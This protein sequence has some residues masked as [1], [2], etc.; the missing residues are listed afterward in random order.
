MKRTKRKYLAALIILTML[1][2]L[3]PLGGLT[4]E[5][6]DIKGHWAEA[7]IQ[8]WLDQGMAGGYPDGAFW[9]DN[10]VTR[11]EFIVLVNRAFD[12]PAFA[13]GVNFA[14]VPDTAWY[15]EDIA[16]AVKAEI[17]SGY[18]DGTFRP[19]AFIT[20][21]EA[22]AVLER[23]LKDKASDVTAFTDDD[24]ITSWA[25]SAVQAISSAGIMNGYP[26]G[27]FRPQNPITR[28]E[29]VVV[30]DRI[31][32][33]MEAVTA[34]ND[35]DYYYDDYSYTPTVSLAAIDD[36]TLKTGQSRD[37]SIDSNATSITA[38]S[39]N[40]DVVSVSVNDKTLTIGGLKKGSAK[41]SVTGMRGGYNSRT[42]TFT[43]EVTD[44]EVVG[45]F[46]VTFEGNGGTPA[47][48]TKV[49]ADGNTVGTLPTVTRD[50]FTFV[51]WNTA[52]NGSGTAFTA[53]T[54]V[55][56]D[57]TVYADWKTIP[58][59]L[60]LWLDA[61]D[62]DESTGNWP[63]KSIE[64]NEVS[65]TEADSR[66]VKAE[67]GFNERP[68]V[69]FDGID[70]YLNLNWTAG[71]FETDEATIFMVL[72]S[73]N[74]DDSQTVMG[75]YG[76]EGAV[77]FHV[78]TN[79]NKLTATV[80]NRGDR[81]DFSDS[82]E[83]YI[84]TYK[85]TPT[86]HTAYVDGSQTATGDLDESINWGTTTIGKNGGPVCDNIEEW[87]WEGNIAEIRIYDHALSDA[88]REEVEEELYD[89]WFGPLDPEPVLAVDFTAVPSLLEETS[90][91]GTGATVGN[92]SVTNGI[93]SITYS[94]TA[95]TG[96]T[97]NG[98][99]TIQGNEVKVGSTALTKGTYS[100][101]V[102]AIDSESNLAVKEFSI[103]VLDE[104]AL[105]VNNPYAGVNWDTVN[106]YKANFHTHTK[107]SSSSGY[108]SDGDSA[109]D[110]VIKAYSDAGYSILALTDHDYSTYSTATTWPWTEFISETPSQI[111][112][113]SGETS[114]D[115]ET[116]ALYPDLGPDGMLA[117]RGNELSNIDHTGSLFSEYGGA[118]SGQEEQALQQIQNRKGLA[119]M[120]H[121]GRYD[122]TLSW[123]ENLYSEY[124]E[125]PLIGMEVYNQGDRYSND[126]A[127]WD[128]LNAALM[129]EKVVFGYSDDDM[130]YLNTHT[131][132]N[133]QFM[134]M[135]ELTEEALRGA[136]HTGASY[137][138]YEPNR[139]G[140]EDP[141]VPRI[142]KIEVT[143]SGTV[144]TITATNAETITWRTNKGIAAT[145]SSVDL[146]TL[147]LAE[148]KFIRAELENNSGTTYTQPFTLGG[149]VPNPETE[150]TVTFSSSEKGSLSAAVDGSAITSGTKVKA[151]KTVVFTAA[152][153]ADY[154]VAEWS[155]NET[156][157]SGETGL[158]YIHANLSGDINVTVIFSEIGS[159]PEPILWLDAADYDAN[160]GQWPDKTGINSVTQTTT[161]SRPARVTDGFNG[162]PIVR[163]DGTEQY[164]S[165]DWGTSLGDS[166]QTDE[167]TIFLVMKDGGVNA[168]QVIMG[169]YNAKDQVAVSKSSQSP[170][171][172]V[173]RIYGSSLY[174]FDSCTFTSEAGPYVLT[175]DYDSETMRTF[176]DGVSANTEDSTRSIN[177]TDT[178]IGCSGTKTDKYWQ[179][180]IAEIRI[181]DCVLSDAER[182][183]IEQDLISK[184]G[185][186]E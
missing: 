11:A 46:T 94:L 86:S 69:G 55:T 129:P 37:I 111:N 95:G 115:Y 151:G 93:G 73:E 96:D 110:V 59:D 103:A 70:D 107:Y 84:A 97:D 179:G 35:D 99:F 61:A 156:P 165:L 174:S 145:G 36:I 141:P 130:H 100:F 112:Y 132:R 82:L 38:E 116:S 178:A 12:I 1:V 184:Y 140:L 4:A 64:D 68:A 10:P 146:T 147:D 128:N 48:Q 118:A 54:A 26:D 136:M 166:L 173:A 50:G 149:Y 47:T 28:A 24:Q 157:L 104:G 19:E 182:A 20:R 34:Y 63:D 66:P 88:E 138:C 27:T 144:I 76:V 117:V 22:A 23:L 162:L 30:L 14:D 49:V 39:D 159:Q 67:T 120:Y 42:E 62:Y 98:R 101:R 52:A 102:Q 8:K 51:Q 143:D 41:I 121:P 168:T 40:K 108:G 53:A 171:P 87:P 109:P 150:Y 15:F 57:I 122:R 126:R 77:F 134:L 65:Q 186:S 3:L 80:S 148:V 113:R 135:E 105:I 71:S 180:D 21:Q 72:E 32:E 170:N 45:T 79:L 125:T 176:V 185:L 9:P 75:N 142:S 58:S 114:A 90:S 169:N 152:P 124:Y 131:F 56:A 16:A 139:S 158:T 177:W 5:N 85:V 74:M 25:K 155:V 60:I 133:Y 175:F 92:L 89:K 181:Y 43:V 83:P 13:S 154:Q 31:L 7:T 164:L 44:G 17:V 123:Y 6:S 137:F 119:I 18:P 78:S 29:T 183:A 167:I 172:I 81:I 153:E 161:T 160:T 163:F 91:V 2:S 33:L 127:L 106:Q